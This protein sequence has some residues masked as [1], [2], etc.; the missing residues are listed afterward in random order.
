MPVTNEGFLWIPEPKNVLSP[1]GDWHP[2]WGVD[3]NDTHPPTPGDQKKTSEVPRLWGSP[4]LLT[5]IVPW[6]AISDS[7]SVKSCRTLAVVCF[8][9]CVFFR[10]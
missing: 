8:G 2:R 6:Q 10:I 5:L 4:G 9:R 3:P 7:G 1:R